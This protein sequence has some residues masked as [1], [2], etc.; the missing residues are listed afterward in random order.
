MSV[1]VTRLP[2]GLT[3]VTDAMPHLE[4]AS[5]GV[6]VQSQLVASTSAEAQSRGSANGKVHAN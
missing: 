1:E 4:S 5:L 2:S 3:V 6:W